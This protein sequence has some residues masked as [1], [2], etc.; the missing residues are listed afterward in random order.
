MLAIFERRV[1]STVTES[2]KAEWKGFYINGTFLE[3]LG[4]V[5]FDRVRRLF[6]SLN[7][8]MPSMTKIAV[9]RYVTRLLT[10]LSNVTTLHAADRDL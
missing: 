1:T 9:V 5:S 3:Q 8:L 2:L 10:H 4:Q 6:C 7:R